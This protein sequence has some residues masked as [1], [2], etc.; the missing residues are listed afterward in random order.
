MGDGEDAGEV[1]GDRVDG[2]DESIDAFFV[3][4]A[5]AF[6][7][8]QHLQGG[9]R[10]L[11]KEAGEGE[12]DGE[13]DAESFAPGVGFV[14]A[15]AS[16]VGDQDVEGVDRFGGLFAF[17]RSGALGDEF[18][19]E[20]VVAE[21]GED[22]VGH[23]FELGQDVFD[24]QGRDAVFAEGL[25]EFLVDAILLLLLLIF[26]EQFDLLLFDLFLL[27][28]ALLKLAEAGE[29]VIERLPIALQFGF[30]LFDAGGGV[31]RLIQAA[32]E[33]FDLL[34]DGL[35]LHGAGLEGLGDGFDAG[36]DL[37]ELLAGLLEFLVFELPGL[38]LAQLMAQLVVLFGA[39][40]D[41][42]ELA[43]EVAELLGIGGFDRGDLLG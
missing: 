13:V 28:L 17:A 8:D 22:L 6:I 14:G 31:D 20:L 27:L 12:A 11:G 19:V 42:C 9:A 7:D 5:E 43:I 39:V 10:S 23:G 41:R 16:G 29:L 38:G 32:L 24:H 2:T 33:K 15:G 18:D 1:L 34:F 40:V 25:G 35:L 21:A 4:G 36:L 3:L 30:E 37:G 26:G